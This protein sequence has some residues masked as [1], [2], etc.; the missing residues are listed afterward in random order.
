MR[1]HQKTSDTAQSSRP[2]ANL[3]PRSG[4]IDPA[5]QSCPPGAA[6]PTSKPRNAEIGELM[7]LHP[8]DNTFMLKHCTACETQHVFG[9]A[10]DLLHGAIHMR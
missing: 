8:C 10:N 3:R 6:A 4:A 1:A 7:L 5:P 2:S 9:V